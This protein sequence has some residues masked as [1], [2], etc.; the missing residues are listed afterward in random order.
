MKRCPFC[1]EEIHDAAIVCKHCGRPV[2]GDTRPM[3]GGPVMKVVIWVIGAV[4]VI[5]ILLSTLR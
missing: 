2:V 4:F 1:A 5:L 3:L